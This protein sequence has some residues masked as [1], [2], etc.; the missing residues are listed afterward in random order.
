MDIMKFLNDLER[1]AGMKARRAAADLEAVL[2]GRTVELYLI[3]GDKLFIVADEADAERLGEP[4]G[5]AY[6]AQEARRVVALKDPGIVREVHAWK[7]RF[8]AILVSATLEEGTSDKP[9]RHSRMRRDRH[10]ETQAFHARQIE[11]AETATLEAIQ[12]QVPRSLTNGKPLS[13]PLE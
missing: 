7:R 9:G 4:R 10:I 11:A 8:N 1:A 3:D 13:S 6:T 2:K 12:R 5:S